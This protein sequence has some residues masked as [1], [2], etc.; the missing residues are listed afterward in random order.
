MRRAPRVIL[1]RQKRKGRGS[2]G[3][4][5][6]E[7]ERRIFPAQVVYPLFAGGIV[8]I[9][10]LHAPVEAEYRKLDVQPQ[11]D[12]RIE[13]QLLVKLVEMKDRIVVFCLHIFTFMT[14]WHYLLGKNSTF[15]C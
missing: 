4:P 15:P 12:P 2:E 5:H 14:T 8:R 10:E 3:I 9:M 13:T 7:I 11:A 6:A 1:R